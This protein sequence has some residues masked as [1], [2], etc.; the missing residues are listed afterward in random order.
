VNTYVT[1]DEGNIP[2]AIGVRMSESALEGLPEQPN[3]TSRC[4]DLNSDGALESGTECLG[5]YE[6]VLVWPREAEAA[7]LPFRWLGLNWNARGHPPAGVYDIPHFDIH[8]YM[9]ERETITSIR[10][11][12]CGEWTDCEDFER[13]RIP[14]AP[15]YFPP[16]YTEVGAVV[17]QMGNH[18]L[19]TASPE[20]ATPPRRFTHTLM[21]GAYEGNII[22]IEPMITREFLLSRPDM[23]VPIA[24]PAEWQKPA[25]YPTRYCVRYR[26]NEAVLTISLEGFVDRRM[27]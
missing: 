22:F 10:S 15:R 7:G 5:D 6:S 19:N 21:Y 8:F 2:V 26:D 13:A 24:Q 1:L 17:A 4:F 14:V 23:C 9:V 25:Y 20:L 12:P 3:N 27:S 16:G 11:G 18:L